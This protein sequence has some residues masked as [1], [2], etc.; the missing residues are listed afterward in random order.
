MKR[1]KKNHKSFFFVFCGLPRRNGQRS[2]GRVRRLFFPAEKQQ[3]GH[4]KTH[5]V[6]L[7]WAATQDQEVQVRVNANTSHFNIK[8]SLIPKYLQ[9]IQLCKNIIIKATSSNGIKL[10]TKYCNFFFCLFSCNEYDIRWCKIL[11]C[12]S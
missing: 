11:F 4:T 8:S 1:E 7:K 6:C 5:S 2:V 10:Q 9:H 12:K 3:S